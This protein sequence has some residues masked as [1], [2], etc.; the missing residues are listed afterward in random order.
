MILGENFRFQPIGNIAIGP[1][2]FGIK[3]PDGVYSG[4]EIL[5]AFLH[6]VR[7]AVEG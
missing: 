4:I 5:K 3:K 2:S 1:E 6:E 7:G